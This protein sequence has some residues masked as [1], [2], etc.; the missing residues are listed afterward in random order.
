MSQ[1]LIGSGLETAGQ[2]VLMVKKREKNM[3]DNRWTFAKIDSVDVLKMKRCGQEQDFPLS[4][5]SIT[6]PPKTELPPFPLKI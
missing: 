5:A 3:D 6:S 4:S 2:G 1:V